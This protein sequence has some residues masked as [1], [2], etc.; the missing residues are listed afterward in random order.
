MSKPE[1]I[2]LIDRRSGKILTESVMGGGALH[3]AY[4]T[5]LGRSLWGLLFDTSLPSRLMGWFYDSRLSRSGIATL[6]KNPGLKPEEAEK[7][8]R[9]YRT[10]NDFFTRKLKDG[11]R[12]AAPGEDV[13]CSPADGRALFYPDI[14]PEAALPVK[15]AMRTLSSLCGET[16][17]GR[18]FS[19]AVIRLAPVD[20]H[21]Y[22]YPCDCRDDGPTKK[23]A[24][25][26]HSVNPAAFRRAPDL[27]I[28]NT[29]CITP[30]FSPRFGRFYYLEIGAFGVGSIVDT[31]PPGE[32]GKMDEKG[33]FK[34]GGST[35][36]LLM[37]SKKVRFDDDLLENSAKPIETLVR[38]GERI[39]TAVC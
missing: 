31:A 10:F 28:E 20:Y 9:E 30:L 14:D 4:D 15:G 32:H 16:L 36:I 12:P 26:Y 7:D 19:A 8:W 34:F 21:R 24:G 11:A 6:L 35:V 29:R 17:P 1:P 2:T 3:F 13:L 5:L 39:G 23:I 25:K 22:H 18:K 27:F 38:C 37:E 33:W